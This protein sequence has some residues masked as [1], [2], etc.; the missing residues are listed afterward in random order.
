MNYLSYIL[1]GVF[2]VATAI[3]TIYIHDTNVLLD[4]KDRRIDAL[5]QAV[6]HHQAQA[7]NARNDADFQRTRCDAFY[8]V[9]GDYV[10][11]TNQLKARGW[12]DSVL[13]N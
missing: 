12:S 1:A 2:M 8:D 5:T 9:V 4:A 10:D 3:Q 13:P 6:D 11:V 7:I